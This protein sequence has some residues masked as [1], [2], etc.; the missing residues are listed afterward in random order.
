MAIAGD[1]LKLLLAHQDDLQAFLA[2]VVRNAHD[3]DDVFQETVLTLWDKFP[4]YD[5]TRSFG[6][7]ARGI[8]V[9]KVLQHRGRSGAVPSPFSPQA[10]AAIVDAFDREAAMGSDAV[11]ALD[12]CMKTDDL[13]QSRIAHIL[14]DLEP[15][16][17]QATPV[18]HSFGPALVNVFS[19]GWPVA[20]LAATAI[21]GIGLVIGAVTHVSQPV[22]VVQ[23]TPPS[24]SGNGAG[25][26]ANWL[27]P[28]ARGRGAGG[29]GGRTADTAQS[30]IVGQITGMVDCRFAA[31]SKTEDRRPKTTVSLGDKFNLVSGLL[32]LTYDTGARVILQGPV[33]YEVE[34]PAGGFLSVGKLTAKVDKGLEIRDKSS[35][36][37]HPS[38]LILCLLSVLPPR[39]SPTSVPNSGSR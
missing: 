20:Y 30:P 18:F 21:L 13:R 8:A 23:E 14:P 28:P 27:P 29:E 39:W 25:G 11:D 6:A 5:P 2:S 24:P 36:I 31:G 16:M 1:F 4:E 38:S 3:R 7:W 26:E 33:T 10:I 37:P 32:E 22:Q 17:P 15:P 9:N 34:S 19:S 12:E 35:D